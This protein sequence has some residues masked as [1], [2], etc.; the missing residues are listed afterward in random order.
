MDR[1]A[2]DGQERMMNDETT[3]LITTTY[4]LIKPQSN[5][6]AARASSNTSASHGQQPSHHTHINTD[7][8]TIIDSNSPKSTLR[9]NSASNNS[10]NLFIPVHLSESVFER[11]TS[12]PSDH[13]RHQYSVKTTINN[14][15]DQG[16][17]KH[18]IASNDDFRII[19]PAGNGVSTNAHSHACTHAEMT[20]RRQPTT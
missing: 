11:D 7:I 13:Y 17:M 9:I 3:R 12:R 4:Y 2:S 15:N 18:R 5:P 1:M 14:D 16:G 20:A 19:A 6:S 8:C 10:I